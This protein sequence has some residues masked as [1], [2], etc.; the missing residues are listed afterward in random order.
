MGSEMCIRDRYKSIIMPTIRS[1]LPRPNGQ[2]LRNPMDSTFALDR[3]VTIE[4][5]PVP[6]YGI[7]L[8]F[9]PREPAHFGD[10]G[11][12]P[13]IHSIQYPRCFDRDRL[14]TGPFLE[15]AN[16][17][18]AAH[19]VS[20]MGKNETIIDAGSQRLSTPKVFRHAEMTRDP[21]HVRHSFSPIRR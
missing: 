11:A 3:A 6:A 12:F 1:S 16:G 8:G 9:T 2:P 15:K 7:R 18:E 5:V 17:A 13:E 14:N 4:V 19:S 20:V 10:G 21:V